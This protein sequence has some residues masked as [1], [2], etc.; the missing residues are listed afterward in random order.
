MSLHL[1]IFPLFGKNFIQGGFDNSIIRG[2]AANVFR[3]LQSLGWTWS[4]PLCCTDAAGTLWQLPLARD[5]RASFCH[6]LRESL[7]SRELALAVSTQR[8]GKLQPHSDLLGVENGVR[9]DETCKLSLFLADYDKGVLQAILSGAISTTEREHR[10]KPNQVASPHCTFCDS[11]QAETREHRWWHCPAWGSLRPH[12]FKEL[13]RS[14]DDLP[15]CFVQCAICPQAYNNG[16]SIDMVQQVFL[17]IQL[18][19]NKNFSSSQ[20]DHGPQQPPAPAP[21]PAVRR[22]LV[23]KQAVF[24]ADPLPC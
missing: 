9:F 8:V 12:W 3:I 17:S 11:Q 18:A 20:A 24:D 23:G 15:P 13:R 7:R 10:H 22:R 21:D 14:L 2:P 1:L 4:S 19:V 6:V 16:P 5:Q